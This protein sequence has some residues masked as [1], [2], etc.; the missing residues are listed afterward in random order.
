M[1]DAP[2][3]RSAA[4]VLL[5]DEDERVLLFRVAGIASR[6]PLWITPGGGLHAGE[7]FEAAALRE[8][9]E[10]TGYSA[11]EPGPMVWRRRHLFRFQ[12]TWLDEDERFFVVRCERFEPGRDGFEDHEHEFMVEHRWWSVDEI[13]VSTDYFAPRR[14][15]ELLPDV[16]SGATRDVIDCG[17]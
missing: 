10:E 6:R 17:V 11:R 13:T 5:I 12:G 9:L 2:L 7:T 4:R 1:D 3:Y 16:L 8:L 14:L 15:A